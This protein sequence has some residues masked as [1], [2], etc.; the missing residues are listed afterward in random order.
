MGFRQGMGSARFWYK[1]GRYIGR[2]LWAGM[3]GLAAL[4]LGLIDARL[5]GVPAMCFV[6]QL[7]A[8][9][10]NERVLKGKRVTETI[11]V[12]PVCTLFCICKICGVLVVWA[13]FCVGKEHAVRRS[14]RLWRKGRRAESPS[15]DHAE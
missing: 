9:A 12:L 13:R 3:L 2:D 10:F 11:V 7:A 4:P 15:S 6:L 5:F 14:K 8:I 1:R